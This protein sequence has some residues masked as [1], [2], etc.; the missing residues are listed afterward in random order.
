MWRREVRPSTEDR[1]DRTRR[2]R[3]TNLAAERRGGRLARISPPPREWRSAVSVPTAIAAFHNDRCRRTRRRPRR[4]SR[5]PPPTSSQHAECVEGLACAHAHAD[6]DR[7]LVLRRGLVERGGDDF[8]LDA[9]RNDQHP[10]AVAKDEVARRDANPLDLDRGAEVDDLAARTLVLRINAAAEGGKFSAS[11]PAAS[12]TKPFK[13]A[14]AALRRVAR[15]DINSPQSAY[16]NDAP[17]A[18]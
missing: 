2:H 1:L 8:L 3:A 11:I 13:T 5:R 9:G 10:F 6:G 12:R 16:R 15:V 14:P 7:H 17:V 18:M 4:R